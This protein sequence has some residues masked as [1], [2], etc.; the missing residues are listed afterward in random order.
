MSE[1]CPSLQDLLDL[2]HGPAQGPLWSHVQTCPRCKATLKAYGHFRAIVESEPIENED[3]AVNR[4]SSAI[5]RVVH[6]QV[7]KPRKALERRNWWTWRRMVPALGLASV[8]AG[9][10]LLLLDQMPERGRPQVFR[11]A[12]PAGQGGAITLLPTRIDSD[13]AM[14]LAWH[15]IPAA[16]SYRVRILD[17]GLKEIARLEAGPESSLVIPDARLQ[18]WLPDG[19]FWQVQAMYEGDRIADSAPRALPVPAHR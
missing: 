9:F 19:A 13:G 10:S 17:P 2:A 11:E 18:P 5:H 8:L 7:E 12:A 16:D 15:P 4:L 14:I 3:S 6:A 1:S